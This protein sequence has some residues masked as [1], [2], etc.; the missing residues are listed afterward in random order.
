MVKLF[1]SHI[2]LALFSI[3]IFQASSQ[4]L[5]SGQPTLPLLSLRIKPNLTSA[6]TC[7]FRVEISTSCS[8]VKYTR[9]QISLSFGDAYG[10]QVYVPR[11]D[12]P[13]SRAFEAC[14]TDT[15]DINGPCT[16]DVCYVY[17]YRR[18]NDGWNVKNVRI[19]SHYIRTVTFNYNAW[20]PKNTWYGFNYC[21]A[22]FASS[23]M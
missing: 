9:D 15:F 20:I 6:S 18:G 1:S 14:S 23:L 16:Y 2:F 12:N 13:S 17:L 5:P 19:S 3:I 21:N 11:I 22:A 7:N 10:N 8:S 4:S